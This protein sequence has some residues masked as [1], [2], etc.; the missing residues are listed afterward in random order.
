MS[1]SRRALWLAVFEQAVRDLT[2]PGATST[3]EGHAR[4]AAER[5]IESHD[6]EQVASMIGINEDVAPALR[7][8]LR[9]I[10]RKSVV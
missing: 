4:L 1:S 7:R 10:D 3:I 2:R 8:R 6:F 5:W 9:G